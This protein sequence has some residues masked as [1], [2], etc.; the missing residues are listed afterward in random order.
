MLK[1]QTHQKSIKK[2]NQ[3]SDLFRGESEDEQRLMFD[4]ACEFSCDHR[5][6]PKRH[7][8]LNRMASVKQNL[9]GNVMSCTEHVSRMLRHLANRRT[10][11]I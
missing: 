11:Q 3:L 9:F 1:Q 2:P 8:M 4:S 10:N 5:Q 7:P 6:T